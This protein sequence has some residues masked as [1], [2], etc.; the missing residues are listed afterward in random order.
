MIT[1]VHTRHRSSDLFDNARRLVAEHDRRRAGEELVQDL[2]VA[3]T[4]TAGADT[5]ADLIV[6]QGPQCDLLDRHRP[7]LFVDDGGARHTSL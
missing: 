7:G 5:D 6:E 1:D 3:V 4:N 2:E